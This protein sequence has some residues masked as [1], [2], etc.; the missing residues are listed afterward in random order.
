MRTA[1]LAAGVVEGNATRASK[2][3]ALEDSALP[4]Q[5]SILAPSPNECAGL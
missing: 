2:A 1:V 4:F 3:D 5:C